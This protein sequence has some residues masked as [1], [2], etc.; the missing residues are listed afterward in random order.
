M[1]I[2]LQHCQKLPLKSKPDHTALV[3]IFAEAVL[4]GYRSHSFGANLLWR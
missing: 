4:E 1:N 3:Q 2:V